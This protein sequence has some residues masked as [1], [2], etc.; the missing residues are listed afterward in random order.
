MLPSHKSFAGVF[1][2]DKLNEAGPVKPN[3]F[4]IINLQDFDKGN[5]S[6]W[7]AFLTGPSKW[8]AYY[9][10]FGLPCPTDVEE[11]VE[12]SNGHSPQYDKIYYSPVKHQMTQS[13]LCG[14][15]VL[16]FIKYM[17]HS[18]NKLLRFQEFVTKVF[19]K[20]ELKNNQKIREI[21]HLL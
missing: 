13:I 9:D 20:E 3:T 17:N 8:I 1:S 4:Y 18:G 16:C 2:K 10:P 12:G 14:Y 5:G 6:H 19:G 7:T 15:Y 21:F 11:Y